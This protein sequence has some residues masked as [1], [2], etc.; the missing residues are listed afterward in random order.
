MADPVEDSP[1]GTAPGPGVSFHDERN[2]TEACRRTTGCCVLEL[3]FDLLVSRKAAGRVGGNLS[4]HVRAHCGCDREVARFRFSSLA[5]REPHVCRSATRPPG[6]VVAV[7][8]LWQET[9]FLALRAEVGV[10]SCGEEDI[11]D[12][13]VPHCAVSVARARRR[14]VAEA[15]K[16]LAAARAESVTASEWNPQAPL[17]LDSEQGRVDLPAVVDGKGCEPSAGAGQST[18]LD[19]GPERSVVSLAVLQLFQGRSVE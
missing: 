10:P 19:V 15:V 3:S 14:V 11:A 18:Q 17:Q 2:E 16:D 8:A 6:Q 12:S 9:C 4:E 7:R 13:V 5:S 1:G